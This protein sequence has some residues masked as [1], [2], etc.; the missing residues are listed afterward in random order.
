V[1]RQLGYAGA[2]SFCTA[3]R[4]ETGRSP[5]QWRALMH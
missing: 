3:F 4:R 2:P 1:A 5:A